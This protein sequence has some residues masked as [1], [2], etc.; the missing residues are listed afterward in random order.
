[1]LDELSELEATKNTAGVYKK[2]INSRLHFWLGMLATP[3]ILEN[4]M[5]FPI[6]WT[7]IVRIS[8]TGELAIAARAVALAAMAIESHKQ[9]S[10]DREPE[11]WQAL[12]ALT[13]FHHR[14][15][16]QPR[17]AL[18]HIV[19]SGPEGVGSWAGRLRSGRRLDMT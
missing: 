14:L 12:C 11:V 17:V 8:R 13:T 18:L 10:S 15:S 4:A 7:P 6:A 1:M 16:R 3:S 9:R 19:F 2:P 5:F